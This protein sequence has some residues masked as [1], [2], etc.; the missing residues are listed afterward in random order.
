MSRRP[1]KP[2]ESKIPPPK[3]SGAKTVA[4]NGNDPVGD[5]SQAGPARQEADK[6]K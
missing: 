4:P 2:D 1:S 5:S 6:S 3:E